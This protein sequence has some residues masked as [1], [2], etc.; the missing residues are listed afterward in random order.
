[1]PNY[2]GYR[3]HNPKNRN[4]IELMM[5][6]CNAAKKEVVLNDLIFA[7]RIN[8]YGQIKRLIEICIKYELIGIISNKPTIYLVTSKGKQLLDLFSYGYSK[9]VVPELA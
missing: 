7:T 6:V 5:M 1:M 9:E 2:K 8:N 3:K 4:Q